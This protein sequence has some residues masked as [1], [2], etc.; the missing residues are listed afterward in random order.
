MSR[1]QVRKQEILRYTQ[2]VNDYQ[3]NTIQTIRKITS[4][5]VESQGYYG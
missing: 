4:N 2:I 1:K 3:Q 5:F